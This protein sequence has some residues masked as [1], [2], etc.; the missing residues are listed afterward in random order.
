MSTPFRTGFV[1][2]T[3]RPN[4]GKSTLLNSLVGEKVAITAPQPQTTRTSLQGVVTTKQAQIIFVDTPGIHESNNLFNKRMMDTVRDALRSRDLLLFVIDGSKSPGIEDE[5]AVSA[6]PSES[7]AILVLNKID[8]VP[9]KRLLLQRIESYMKLFPFAEAAPVSARSGDG[10]PQLQNLITKY[11]P[12]GPPQYSDEYLTNQPMRFI[13]AEI[14][15]E[16]ILSV[17]RQ[18]VPH[19]VAVLV[20]EWEETPRLTRI[21][22]TIYVERSGQKTILIGS[23]GQMLKK[24]GTAARKELEERLEQK[25]FLSLFVKVKPGWREDP[26]FLKTMDWRS[27]LGS[28]EE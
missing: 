25:V 19:A 24:V 27:M 13:A 11:L 22:A 28:G 16:K 8:Q 20:D 5:H 12:E 6:L 23:G 26:S 10:L 18:E 9:D 1:S 7:T 15:R 2:L 3:G 21:T 17:A 4:V 14:V